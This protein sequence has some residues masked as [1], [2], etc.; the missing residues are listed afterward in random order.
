MTSRIHLCIAAS[1]L[2][3]LGSTPAWAKPTPAQACAAAKM[4]AA[5]NKAK[6]KLGCHATAAKKGLPVDAECLMKAESKFVEAFQKAE[7]KGGC[8]TVNDAASIESI[9]DVFVNSIVAALPTVAP[10]PLNRIFVS[11]AGYPGNFGGLSGADAACQGLATAAGLPG[12]YK[13]WLSDATTSAATRLGHSSAPYRLVDGTLVANNWSDLTDGALLAPINLTE[14]AGT[15]SPGDL[16][17][18]GTDEFGGSSSQ[19]CQNWTSNA[20]GHSATVGVT[21]LT[22]FNWTRRAVTSCDLVYRL[23]CLQQ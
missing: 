15:V 1:I 13:A 8:A 7:D 21:N 5:A 14:V 3:G 18:T 2:F 4:K 12:T 17:A 10:P 20:A 22:D 19:N 6:K 9:V 23:Y 11:S 16:V